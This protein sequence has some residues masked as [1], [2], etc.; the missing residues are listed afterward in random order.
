MSGGDTV[1][2]LDNIEKPLNIPQKGRENFFGFFG[3]FVV[4][5]YFYHQFFFIQLS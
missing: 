2:E 1:D 4:F 5:L 3:N